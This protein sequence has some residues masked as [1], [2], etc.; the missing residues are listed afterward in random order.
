MLL[1]H[2]LWPDV[3][4]HRRTD[5]RLRPVHSGDYSHLGLDIPLWVYIV[6]QTVFCA[7]AA[8]IVSGSMAERTNFKAYCVYSAAISLVVYPICGHW[9]WGG[10]WLQSMGFHDFAGSAAVHNVGGV[11]A[12]LGAWMLGPRIGKYDKNG[13][14]HA[15]PGHNL[16]AGAL[17]CSSCGSAGS[18]STAAPL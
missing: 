6:F 16:T 5:R 12:L 15:I 1:D 3:R 18:A 7:T 10:G 11:I 4:R 17:A 9:M 14:P 2:R 13:K 8:T